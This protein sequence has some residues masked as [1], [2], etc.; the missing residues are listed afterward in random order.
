MIE[1]GREGDHPQK[2]T[3]GDN[4]AWRCTSA[5]LPVR[6]PISPT[7]VLSGPKAGGCVLIWV[8]NLPEEGEAEGVSV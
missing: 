7:H 3:T 5:P 1:R 8:G 2:G 4:T 6:C